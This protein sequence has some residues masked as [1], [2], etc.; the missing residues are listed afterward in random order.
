MIT[1]VY[2]GRL[3]NILFQNIGKSIISEKFNLKVDSY[4]NDEFSILGLKLFES[5]TITHNNLEHVGDEQVMDVLNRESVDNGF[6]LSGL[7]Q[8]KDFVIEYE[9]KIR[10]HFNLKYNNVN[11]NDVFIH[12]RLGDTENRF[13]WQTMDYYEKALSQINY[14]NIY[15]SSDSMYSNLV[16]SLVIKYNMI[17]YSNTPVETINFAKDFNNLVLSQG[18]FSWWIGFL[19]KAENIYFPKGGEIWHGNIFVFDNWKPIEI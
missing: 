11:E 19:S 17:P 15:I 1:S 2:Q 5:G 10:S 9:N 7:F 4:L 16:K 12:I 6:Y 14:N 3:G 8:I 18:T 13:I